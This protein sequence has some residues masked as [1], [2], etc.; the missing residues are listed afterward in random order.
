MLVLV[1]TNYFLQVYYPLCSPPE[2][3]TTVPVG[4]GFGFGARAIDC[5]DDGLG[6]VYNAIAIIIVSNG[7]GLAIGGGGG[8]GDVGN[9]A[10][11]RIGRVGDDAVEAGISGDS[12]GYG[13]AIGIGR[14]HG[15]GHRASGAIA[16]GKSCLAGNLGTIGVFDIGQISLEIDRGDAKLR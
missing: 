12:L 7:N 9:R 6:F 16:S 3:C 15:V 4:Q 13:V 8:F 2:F 5:G 10:I 14:Q 1:Y 11:C